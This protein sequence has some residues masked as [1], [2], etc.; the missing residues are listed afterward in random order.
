VAATARSSRTKVIASFAAKYHIPGAY[1]VIMD[2]PIETRD[3]VRATLQM[4][5]EMDRPFTLPIYSLKVIPNTGLAEAMAERGLDLQEIDDSYLIVPA[6]A[7]NL[8]LY[9]VA[10]FRP[11]HW[12]WRLMM[13]TVRASHEPQRLY[14]RLGLILRTLYLSKRALSH[15][16]VMDFSI[17]P[18]RSGYIFW[19]IGLVPLW[20]KRLWRRPARPA[21]T[22]VK[23]AGGRD[24]IKVGFQVIGPDGAD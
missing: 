15:I 4:L 22:V 14:P 21:R 20:Q 1:D 16:R 11:P 13:R 5:Y 6:R 19:K 24:E 10:L 23:K 9:V 2:N 18:G 3:D 12:M 17:I 7:A 8:L